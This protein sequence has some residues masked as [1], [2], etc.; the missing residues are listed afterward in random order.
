MTLYKQIQELIKTG[1]LDRKFN[2]VDSEMSEAS[3]LVSTSS[4]KEDIEKRRHRINHQSIRSAL[5]D[6]EMETNWVSFR[7]KYEIFYFIVGSVG[8]E[9]TRAVCKVPRLNF[10]FFFWGIYNT[11]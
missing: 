8:L 4:E 9:Y 7:E 11:Q 2:S 3:T 5:S 1:K 6:S 10:S